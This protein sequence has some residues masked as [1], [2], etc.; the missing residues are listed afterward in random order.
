[1]SIHDRRSFLKLLCISACGFVGNM[2][3]IKGRHAG[4]TLSDTQSL[5]E[6]EFYKKH[7]LTG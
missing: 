7:N 2:M 4:I 6:A 3:G 1:M 5:K